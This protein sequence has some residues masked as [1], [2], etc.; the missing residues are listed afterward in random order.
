MPVFVQGESISTL[1][2]QVTPPTISFIKREESRETT[3]LFTELDTWDMDRSFVISSVL[4]PAKDRSQLSFL[5]DSDFEYLYFVT[6]TELPSEK[7]VAAFKK[8]GDAEK[9]IK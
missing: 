4:K 2:S 7:V 5:E 8:R 9:Y 1:A 6:N 3:E